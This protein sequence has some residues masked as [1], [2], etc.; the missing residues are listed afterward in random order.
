MGWT[1][2]NNQAFMTYMGTTPSYDGS[3]TNDTG[4]PV[5]I[6]SFW[7]YWGI[8]AANYVFADAES[9]VAMVGDGTAISLYVDAASSSSGTLTSLGT[10]STVSVTN[11][12]Y[13]DTLI[14][15]YPA[16]SEAEGGC[17][18]RYDSNDDGSITNADKL[19]W[20]VGTSMDTSTVQK[21]EVTFDPGIIVEDGATV[22]MRSSWNTALSSRHTRVPNSG[23][24][25]IRVSREGIGGTVE[26]YNVNHTVTLSK[27]TGISAVSGAG[28]Y[29]EGDRVTLGATVQEGYQWS[30]WTGTYT[31]TTKAYSFDMPDSDVSMTA[32]ATIITYPISY[33]ANGGGGAPSGQT[34]TYGTAL[35]L[36][37]ATPSTAKQYTMTFDSNGGSAV[38]AITRKCTFNKWN[39]A[40]DGSG[41]SYSPG[42]SYTANASA[43][44]YAQWTN[45]AAGTLPTPT[46]T[47]AKFL[48]WFTAKSGGT[49]VTSTTT[50]TGNI[51][52]Y[53]RWEYSVIY[54]PNHGDSGDAYD[55]EGLC[56]VS[57]PATQTK[58][59]G[60]TL[61]LSSLAADWP[62]KTF[63]GWNTKADGS[64]TGYSPGSAYTINAPVILYA[65]WGIPKYIVQFSTNGGKWPD[66]TTANK[67]Y[68]VQ[69]GNSVTPPAS[70]TREGKSFQGWNGDYTC[71]TS[72][73]TISAIW[74]GSP[75]WIMTASGWVRFLNE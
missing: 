38:S 32:N 20:C 4:G 39:T 10:S 65:Q 11:L 73:R 43:T 51:T 74:S 2:R 41:T 40:S 70:P 8:G 59:Y 47:N 66:G 5:I 9:A 55:E 28:D 13:T 72:N 61:Y 42:G 19:D 50:L 56:I 34:K 53:A 69:R 21:Y 33:N 68:T 45:P 71:I 49:Q 3:Y 18:T 75:V 24:V 67:S 54:N 1:K 52:L 35:T 7:T 29:A 63:T 22:Y 15:D 48:G 17:Y 6:K 62:G 57:V 26:P 37:S 16:G 60:T 27:G 12:V 30:K 36:T 58:Q 31:S 14:S 46:Y 44:L 25:M 23:A 64:G